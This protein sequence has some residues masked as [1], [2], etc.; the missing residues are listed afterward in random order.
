MTQTVYKSAGKQAVRLVWLLTAVGVGSGLLFLVIVWWAFNSFMSEVA[1]LADVDQEGARVFRT[2]DQCIEEGRRELTFILGGGVGQVSFRDWHGRA[3]AVLDEIRNRDELSGL[4]GITDMTVQQLADMHR[5]RSQCAEWRM[6][7]DRVDRQSHEAE[8]RLESVLGALR[9]SVARTAGVQRL[10]QADAIRRYRHAQEDEARQMSRS[11]IE[12]LVP[13]TSLAPVQNELT[14]LSLEIARLTGETELDYLVDYRENRIRPVL[15]RLE[16]ELSHLG[17]PNAES[18]PPPIELLGAI[19]HA[20]FGEDTH[21]DPADG[22]MELGRGGLYALLRNRL[23]LERRR[24][25]LESD[26]ANV[27]AQWAEVRYEME[28]IQARFR[29]D[30]ADRANAQSHR[31]WQVMVALGLLSWAIFLIAARRITNA[32]GVQ[33]ATVEA[34]NLKLDQQASALADVNAQLE[35]AI[36]HANRMADEAESANAAKSQFLAT[37]SHEIRTPLNGV[38]GM[39]EL[40]MISDLSPEQADYAKSLRES[41]EALLAVINDILDFSKIEAGKVELECIDFDARH[42][43]ESVGEMLAPRAQ[44]KG[45]EFAV[46]FAPALPTWLKGDPGRLRQILVNLAGNAIK[47]TQHGE[48]VIRVFRD[49]HVSEQADGCIPV[50]FEVTDTG[51]GISPEVE[52]LLFRPFTQAD[53]TTTRRFG[54]TGLGLTISKQLCEAM[55]GAIGVNSRPGHGSTFWVAIAFEPGAPTPAEAS[56]PDTAALAG[57]RIL[58]VDD[59]STNRQIFR[60]YLLSFG[61]HVSEAESGQQALATLAAVSSEPAKP[62]DVAV[63]DSRMG[64]M[65]GAELGRRIREKPVLSTL[66]LVLTT[67]APARGDAARLLELGFDAYLVKPIR[68][69]R[70]LNTLALV[71]AGR[72]PELDAEQH[73]LVTRHTLAEAASVRILLVDDNEMNRKLGAQMLL[74]LGFL[75]DVCGNGREALEAV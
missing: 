60:E 62:Y 3:L 73:R 40:L 27:F 59:N 39:S 11:V 64:D 12:L 8:Q 63:I 9:E 33:V 70:L 1:R 56:S 4:A 51:I 67:S 61:C 66:H 75:C 69:D 71:I 15:L 28:P 43:V 55:G 13:A 35:Q 18:G 48:V 5:L 24:R 58:V 54:G 72:A 65:D 16:G 53:Q 34:A 10:R 49:Q 23:A 46:L 32:V 41:G 6:E 20:L 38:I 42:L 30:L 29:R 45:L 21:Y 50:R 37:M 25:E 31:G 52:E 17:P 2:V 26:I 14:D 57:A 22:S 68:R 19:E 7:V 47:F 74:K 36:A 44:G